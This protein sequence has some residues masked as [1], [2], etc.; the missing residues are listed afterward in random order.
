MDQSTPLTRDSSVSAPQQET[1]VVNSLDKK[2][3]DMR[4]EAEVLPQSY[5]TSIKDSTPTEDTAADRGTRSTPPEEGVHTAD[6][7]HGEGAAGT[8]ADTGKPAS[9][10]S[11]GTTGDTAAQQI[12]L[13]TLP[14]EGAH[15]AEG[16]HGEDSVITL[17]DTGKP[18]LAQRSSPLRLD[19]DSGPVRCARHPG[20]PGSSWWQKA[21]E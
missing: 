19:L 12:A 17:A 1:T 18:V 4:T 11:Q 16:P 15:T 5:G 6:G 3:E 8:L 14:E 9:A 21:L 20:Q 10:P 7:T 2:V 13:S